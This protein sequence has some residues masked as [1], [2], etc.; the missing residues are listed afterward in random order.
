MEIL[1]VLVQILFVF[2]KCSLVFFLV[3]WMFMLLFA[4]KLVLLPILLYVVC[5]APSTVKYVVRCLI[6]GAQV[7]TARYISI[8]TDGQDL[9]SQKKNWPF[10]V[11]LGSRR[12]YLMPKWPY[13]TALNFKHYL[14][15]YYYYTLLWTFASRKNINPTPPVSPAAQHP[16]SITCFACSQSHIFIFLYY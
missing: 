4:I 16:T 12:L 11:F 9:F 14:L 15:Y 2:L 5:S 10:T 3:C 13:G 1:F 8:L 6:N 7:L